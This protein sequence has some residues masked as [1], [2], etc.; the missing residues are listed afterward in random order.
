MTND[1]GSIPTAGEA[2]ARFLVT[3]HWTLDIHW[4][5]VIGHL[6]RSF[7]LGPIDFQFRVR[8]NV[9]RVH[10]RDDDAGGGFLGGVASVA[11]DDA[12]DARADLLRELNGGHEV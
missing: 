1:Q 10:R 12:E 7:P 9:L 3:G 5:L 4:S 2:D 8:G 6:L 11:P